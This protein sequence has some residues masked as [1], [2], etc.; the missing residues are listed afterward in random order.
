MKPAKRTKPSG[1]RLSRRRRVHRL[2]WAAFLTAVPAVA[3]AVHP[4]VSQD[5]IGICFFR[6][7]T[8]IPCPFCG[9]TRA[10]ACAAR[11]QFDKA[12]EH[13]PFW[14]AVALAVV[15]VDLLLIL[16]AA[17]G[18]D[19]LGGAA[20]KLRPCWPILAAVLV[21]FGVVRALGLV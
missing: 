16:D 1:V 2:V 18:T 5:M 4:I 6:T 8:G 9:L 10:F 12:V 13:H 14:Y 19:T 15:I 21:A 17:F 3:W 7:V 20:R 11:G